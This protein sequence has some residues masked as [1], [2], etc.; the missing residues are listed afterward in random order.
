MDP[1]KVQGMIEWP[2]PRNI[3]E[4][5]AVLRFGNY[6]KDFIENYSLIT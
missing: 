1:I 3:R 4:L 2:V 6:Y 5:H